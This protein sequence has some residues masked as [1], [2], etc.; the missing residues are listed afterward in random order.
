MWDDPRR[1]T[2]SSIS[3]ADQRYG[4]R[5]IMEMY[6]KSTSDAARSTRPETPGEASTSEFSI[7]VESD[8]VSARPPST[9]VQSRHFALLG[10]SFLSSA[11]PAVWGGCRKQA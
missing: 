3:A 11:V 6:C 7:E 2:R 5:R 10:F 8:V 1:F 9:S 4:G